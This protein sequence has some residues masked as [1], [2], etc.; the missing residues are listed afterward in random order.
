MTTISLI[1]SGLVGITHTNARV[2][3]AGQFRTIR[4]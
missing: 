3:G 4:I 1:G 2:G